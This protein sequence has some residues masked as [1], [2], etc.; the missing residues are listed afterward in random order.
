[1]TDDLCKLFDS[2]DSF[3]PANDETSFCINAFLKKEIIRE[4]EDIALFNKK[5]VGEKEKFFKKKNYNNN[6]NYVS[7][8]N[9]ST[10]I[11]RGGSFC[12]ISEYKN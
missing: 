1:M 3:F 2:I 6:L 8:C 5:D 12:E 10:T 11:L 9:D 4:V 7:Y